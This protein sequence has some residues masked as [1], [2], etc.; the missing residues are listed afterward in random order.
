LPKNAASTWR[1]MSR[2]SPLPTV[3]AA[4]GLESSASSRVMIVR[5][6]TL[7]GVTSTSSRSASDGAISSPSATHA[8]D[9]SAVI[10]GMR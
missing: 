9:G 2:A 4:S 7:V 6:A 1:A 8:A 5:P 3:A 10:T